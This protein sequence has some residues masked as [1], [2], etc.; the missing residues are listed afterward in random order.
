MISLIILLIYIFYIATKHGIPHSL[1]QTYYLL[2][3]K[4]IFSVVLLS[5]VCIILP[6]MLEMNY[7]YL[8]FP[9]LC[10]VIFV[11]FTPNF[12]DD[13]LVDRVHTW[14]AIVALI[15]SQIWVG[16]T[17]TWIL[18]LWIPFIMYLCVQYKKYRSF[19]RILDESNSK[20]YA[21]I[22]MLLTVCLCL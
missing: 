22:I 19:K 15:F 13:D 21:E 5:S 12:K 6:Q 3:H 16:V 4:W 8:A 7:S 9:A 1:S 18:C 17:N 20:F 2:K 14:S 11:A 10:G